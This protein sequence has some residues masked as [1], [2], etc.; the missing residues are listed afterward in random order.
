MKNI[1]IAL[2]LVA[3]TGCATTVPSVKTVTVNRPVPYVPTPPNVPVCTNYI[4]TLTQA[5]IKDPGKVVQA[6]KLDMS[7][8]RANDVTFRKII[9]EY[10]RVSENNAD[11]KVLLDDMIKEYESALSNAVTP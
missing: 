8:Y 6:Y 7:C 10:R 9:E 5:D 2:A 3:I 1:L 11:V 4:D